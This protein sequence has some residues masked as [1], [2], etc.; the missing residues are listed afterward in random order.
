MRSI[1]MACAGP[2]AQLM[3]ITVS[4]KL[5]LWARALLALSL[6]GFA[7]RVSHASENHDK[8]DNLIICSA[9]LPPYAYLK[10]GEATGI[11]VD[12]AK[13]LFDAMQVP[14]KINIAPFARCMLEI[15]TG[16]ADV[17]F[18]I[19]PTPEREAIAYFPKTSVWR[20]SYVFFTNE[21]TK[22]RID[23]R[24]LE[25]AKKSKLQIGIV[26]GA[27][28]QKDFWRVFPNREDGVNEGYDHALIAAPDTAE[29]FH[30]LALNHI[31]LFPQDL[32]AGLWTTKMMGMPANY[33]DTV[34]FTKE[35]ANAFSKASTFSNAHYANIEALMKDYDTRLAAFKKTAQYRA[36]FEPQ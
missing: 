35:Y 16:Q 17:V 8:H 14:I 36:L 12:I 33:Y 27:S 22:Q 5:S 32:V 11:D 31:Q 26:R 20:I 21:S 34:L 28:Y 2:G 10:G 7:S 15:G 1:D 13:T 30:Q 18:A 25:D 4:F 6:A 9:P 3:S 24:T 23:I 19:S 29:N